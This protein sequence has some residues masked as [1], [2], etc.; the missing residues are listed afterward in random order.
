MNFYSATFEAFKRFAAHRRSLRTVETRTYVFILVPFEF[1]GNGRAARAE[2]AQNLIDN[3][4]RSHGA[5]NHT[6]ATLTTVDC[7]ETPALTKTTGVRNLN[8]EA[9]LNYEL[10]WTWFLPNPLWPPKKRE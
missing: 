10:M 2:V 8:G 7:T 4:R 6:L 9:E 1:D 5:R 3:D